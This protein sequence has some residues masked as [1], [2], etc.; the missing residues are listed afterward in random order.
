MAVASHWL[1]AVSYT[2][3]DVYKRQLFVSSSNDCDVTVVP[4]LSAN[5]ITMAFSMAL[6]LASSYEILPEYV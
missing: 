2:H 1:L 6:V 5:A 4:N 3:L